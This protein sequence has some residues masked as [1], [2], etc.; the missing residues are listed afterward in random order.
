MD[1]GSVTATKV[2]NGRREC[3]RHKG[4]ETAS[5]RTSV[6]SPIGKLGAVSKYLLQATADGIR[7]K[8]ALESRG[9]I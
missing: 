6:E 3:Q 5:F 4:S 1:D 9:E 7:R 2:P 8:M